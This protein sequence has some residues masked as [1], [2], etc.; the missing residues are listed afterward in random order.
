MQN[1]VNLMF[2]QKGIGHTVKNGRAL[3]R[4]AI[5]MGYSNI[6]QAVNSRLLSYT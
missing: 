5:V 1:I 4:I 3:Y 6:D 2:H